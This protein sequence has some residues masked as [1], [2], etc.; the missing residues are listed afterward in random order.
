MV[1]LRKLR[2]AQETDLEKHRIPAGATDGSVL[3]LRLDNVPVMG[4]LAVIT[5]H[6]GMASSYDCCYC[7]CAGQYSATGGADAAPF[8][9]AAAR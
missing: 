1:D 8:A 2:D 6:G 9:M 4:R 5:R 7:H 3:W